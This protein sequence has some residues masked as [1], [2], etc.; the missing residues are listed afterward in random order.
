MPGS[1]HKLADNLKHAQKLHPIQVI[2][3]LFVFFKG[4]I[5]DIPQKLAQKFLILREV[6]W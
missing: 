5:D 4:I 6:V 3:G 1:D 2:L